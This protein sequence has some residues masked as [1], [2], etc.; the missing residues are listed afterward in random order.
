LELIDLEGGC[1]VHESEAAHGRLTVRGSSAVALARGAYD[2][3]RR[4]GLGMV[5]WEGTRA[6]LPARFPDLAWRRA[7]A[8]TPWRH[9]FNV[10]T[11]GYTMPWWDFVRWE[12]E[13]DW[14]AL[15]GIN[16]PLAME[17]QE[18]I[19]AEVWDSL[20]IPREELKDHFCGPAFLP[21]QRMGG[22]DG[23]AG[24]L[25]ERWIENRAAL[26]R[27]I[28]DR[29]RELGMQAVTPGFAGFVPRALGV[30]QPDVKLVPT[31]GWCGFEPTRMVDFGD[32][33]F[34]EIGRRFIAA[35]RARYGS[36][37][38]YLVDSFN[39]I[40]PQFPAGEKMERLAGV[41]EAIHAGI[42]AG[43]PDGNWVMQGWLFVVRKYWGAAEVRALLSRVPA[44]RAVI[45][46][47]AGDILESWRK[48]GAF[49]PHRWIDC[50]LHNFGG[51]TSLCGDLPFYA[52]RH[53][54]VMQDP[55][56]G[57][58]VGQG[59]T[60]EGTEQNSVVYELLCD[61]M[62]Q[63]DAVELDEWLQQWC[64]ARYGS[65][66][67]QL[68]DAWR[69]LA[70]GVYARRIAF[71]SRAMMPLY[72]RRPVLGILTSA[73]T[74]GR[75]ELRSGDDLHPPPPPSPV[76]AAWLLVRAASGL[77]M[78]PLLRRDLVDVVKRVLADLADAQI[79]RA[80]DAFARR[81][82]VA[83]AD[84]GESLQRLLA[85]IDDVVA[86]CPELHLDAWVER[87]RNATD[88]EA[89]RE[90]HVLNARLQVTA[91]AG[92]PGTDPNLVDYAKKEW[93]GL[94]RDYH[95]PRWRQFH[96][97]LV[98]CLQRNAEFDGALWDEDMA[99]WEMDWV[100]NPGDSPA[101]V[102]EGGELAACLGA[103]KRWGSEATV[104]A[105]V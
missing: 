77:A 39:E 58:L 16:M 2:A 30:A 50:T 38:L 78:T 28:M 18:A 29:Y 32:P 61:T 10:V 37:G 51:S 20:G 5:C 41:G 95:A 93:A 102:A 92:A 85:D 6:E 14:M 27:Q 52:Q 67:L 13:I 4:A 79:L 34:V 105:S 23:H 71:F 35:Y 63:R 54:K 11:F 62:W 25:P 96:D 89:E 65:T 103:L 98:D 87:A 104:A 88:D 86:Q 44:G 80:E 76:D 26:Q 48:H 53:A 9:F 70:R 100:R 49:A 43:D 24:P 74:E 72:T 90:V 33:M 68:V 60:P 64:L 75:S 83:L 8:N 84:A 94:I 66:D 73:K 91:W 46:D 99:R 19:W 56:H 55:G 7:R 97:R 40:M 69:T 101:A 36:A 1:D 21:W 81:D 15:H 59:I 22:V 45:L 57:N 42:H 31:S 12:R 17:G 47:L 3:V 82:A